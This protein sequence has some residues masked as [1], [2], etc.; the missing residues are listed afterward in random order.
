MAKRTSRDLDKQSFWQTKIRAQS[1]SGLTIRAYC[2]KHRLPESAYYFWRREL[3]RRGVGPK[4]KAGFV[5][6]RV[7]VDPPTEG[8]VASPEM[9]VGG[10]IEI[11]LARGCRIRLVGPVDTPVL[12]EVLSVLEGR[13]C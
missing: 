6:V 11:V 2:R 4:S 5:P 7:T 12:R 10:R 13:S 8:H 9:P 1:N 3:A